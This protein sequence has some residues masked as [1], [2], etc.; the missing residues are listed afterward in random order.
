MMH[1]H[2]RRRFLK[3]ALGGVVATTTVPLM[4]H[5]S[6]VNV[7]SLDRAA[8]ALGAMDPGNE[9]F[10]QFVKNQFPLRPDLTL[11]NAAN[12][13]PSPYPVID[14]VTRLTRDVDADASFQNRAKFGALRE[15]ARESLAR[16]LGADPDEI[17]IVRN[18]SEGN[19][20][21]INGLTLGPREEVVIWDQNHPSCNVAWDVRAER[22]GFTVKRVA[23][24][25]SPTTA[26]EL[27]RPFHEALTSRTRVLAFSHVSNISGVGLP[28]EE[29]CRLARE[30]GILTLIDG[31]QVFGALRVN[32]HAIGCDFYTGSAHKWFVGPKEAGVLYVRRERIA[33]HWP[34]NVGVGWEGALERGAAKFE[35][36]GQR[37]DACVAAVG[38]TVAFHEAIGPD[39]VEQRVR[40]LAAALKH[41]L[42]QRIPGVRF[43]TP[44]DPKLS[45][46]V[47]VFAPPRGE[48]R[49]LFEALYRE[50]AIA[51]AAMGGA[52]A[53][54][55]LCPHIY[56]TME[57]VERAAEAVAELV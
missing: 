20:T 50:H 18:T 44:T 10:W 52:F 46:G 57:Q 19:N 43:H 40:A 24:P 13:C 45:A 42:K 38:T 7:G 15:R 5:T 37:D 35:T 54:V 49:Q 27:V 4:T 6:R 53:G 21:V 41:A 55:R 47:V 32:L 11:M 25:P 12:L 28:A 33:E 36:L 3:Q 14:T 22:Y 51:G 48:V 9:S 17:T 39:R 30:R 34:S 29:I 1:A 2:T 26:E 8:S 56:N 31:A 23:T 16:Y